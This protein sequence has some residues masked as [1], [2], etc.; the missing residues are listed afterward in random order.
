MIPT[1]KLP[2]YKAPNRQKAKGRWESYM[3][4]I[5]T[6]DAKYYE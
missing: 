2:K 1:W 3:I 5:I 4:T 6:K